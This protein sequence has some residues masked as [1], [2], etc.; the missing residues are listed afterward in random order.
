MSGEAQHAMGEAGTRSL[1]PASATSAITFCLWSLKVLLCPL[2]FGIS[3]P[4]LDD[5][6]TLDY[7]VSLPYSPSFFLF[8][9]NCLLSTSSMSASPFCFTASLSLVYISPFLNMF[10]HLNLH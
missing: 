7:G 6:L 8:L 10:L 9:T 4:H 3:V 1:A 2:P 5:A